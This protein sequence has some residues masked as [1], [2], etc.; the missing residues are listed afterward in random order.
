MKIGIDTREIQNG[1]VTGIGRSLANLINYFIKVDTRHTLILF[2]E[3]NLPINLN[4]KVRQVTLNK[5][6]TII[7]DQKKLP[8]ALNKHGVDLFYSP[9]YKIPLFTNVPTVSQI[10]DLMFVLHPQYKKNLNL[11]QKFYYNFF[12]KAFARKSVSIITDS[13]HAKNDIIRQWKVNPKKIIVIPLGLAGRYKPVKDKNLLK[14]VRSK[15][16]LPQKYILYLGNFKP[17]KNVSALIQAYKV[18]EN[19]FPDYKLV[20]AGTLDK[21][22]TKTKDYAAQQGLKNKV[23]FTDTVREKD[24]PEAIISM[25][26]VF[27]FPTLYEG[28]GLPPL[29]AMA[30]GTPVVASNITSV[31][32]V[33]GNA[34]ILVNPLNIEELS[35]AISDL[36]RSPKKQMF[37][38]EKGLKRAKIFSE[39]NT[40]GK[41]Y[42]H[43]I[44][45]L[46]EVK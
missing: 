19:K 27:V 42:E 46:E 23:I 33:V 24:Y 44:S 43:I 37:Y 36:L 39:K 32:E 15:L 29:E 31:P 28:F 40:T 2:S 18:I 7:W 30:C 9:Y 6:H 34:G 1:V 5:C 16:N 25:A 4:N 38:S 11:S 21:H 8:K 45:V 17:H 3:K 41:L 22:G 14:Q 20:L 26:D 35:E 13:K 12:G 10:L